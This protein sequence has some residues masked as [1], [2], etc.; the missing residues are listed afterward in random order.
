MKIQIKIALLFSLVC[1]IVIVGLSCAVYYFANENAFEDF[2]VRLQLRAT[3][4]A[5]INLDPDEENAAAYE[6][7]RTIHLQ[8]LPEEREYIYRIDSLSLLA[9]SELKDKVPPG[10]FRDIFLE[11]EASHRNGYQFFKGVY[12]NTT[13]GGYAV[14]ISAMHI[15]ALNF[16]KNLKTILITVNIISLIIVY[17][18]GLVFSN[19]ILE[20]ILK[21]SAEVNNISATSLHKRLSV[22]KGNDAIAELGQTFNNMLSR[23]ETSF[24]TQNNFVSNASHELNTPL[25]AVIGEAELALSKP[26]DTEQYQKSLQVILNQ[27]EK[28]KNITK[29]LIELAQSGFTDNLSYEDVHVHEL[30]KN[31]QR[32]TQSI[33]PDCQLVVDES[34]HPEN[35][36]SL[37]VKGNFQ[38]LELCI[39]N[40]ILN[41]CK[42][43]SG[44]VVTAAIASSQKHVIFIVKDKGI[45]IPEQDMP[46]I[47][48]PFFRASNTNASVGYGIGLPLARNIIKLHGGT[49]HIASKEAEGTEV[50]VKVPK[51]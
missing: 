26:R 39:S 17:W 16:L 38:L 47:F 23:L 20:P 45:G 35:V 40:I 43:S 22:K 44:E 6:Q 28:L 46:H 12:Y 37:S 15:Y 25:T 11:K 33:Y 36:E 18:I 3:I 5:K 21:I 50:V 13:K 49:I 1:T 31:V 27:A 10:F 19:R 32:I 9:N 30:L 41:A 34:L 7:L 51:G 2:Y 8:V 29:S 14:I 48:D 4:A 42:Y 24:E